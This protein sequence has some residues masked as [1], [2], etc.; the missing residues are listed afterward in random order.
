MVMKKK[1][2]TITQKRLKELNL[3]VA[4]R[5]KRHP[6]KMTRTTYLKKRDML[7]KRFNKMKNTLRQRRK[8]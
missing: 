4:E 3:W 2:V 8:K 7:R 5:M 1:Q 6:T